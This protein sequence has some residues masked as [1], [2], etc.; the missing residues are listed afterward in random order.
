MDYISPFTNRINAIIGAIVAIFSYFLGNHW[1]LFLAYLLLNVGDTVSRWIAAWLTGTEDSKLAARGIIK[2]FGYWVLIALSFGMG[3]IFIEIGEI[4]GI[5]LGVTT[6]LGW[7]VLASLFIN[8]IRSILENLV[9]A[10]I[11]VPKFVLKGLEIANKAIDGTIHFE[12]G[13]T[14]D[15]IYNVNLQSA[16]KDLA[17]KKRITLEVSS[18]NKKVE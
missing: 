12:D 7:F 2:K 11:W 5:D 8:E 3:A 10:G 14:E 6:L 9:D 17:N 13:E 15:D 1:W 4:I 16:V 18:K